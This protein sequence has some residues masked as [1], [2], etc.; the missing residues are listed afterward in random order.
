MLSFIFTLFGIG[1]MVLVH[2]AGHF[3]AARFFK[4]RTDEFSIGFGPV[5]WSR[6][7]AGVQYSIRALPF[8]GFVKIYG[9]RG[10]G[11]GEANSFASRP[12]WQRAVVLVAGVF[13]NVVLAWIFFSSA[14]ILGVPQI[15]EERDTFA[16]VSVLMV[17]PDSPADKAGLKF[18][19]EILQMKS[20]D[21]SLRI[22]SEKDVKD[23][24][25]AY[26]GETITMTVKRGSQI[27]DI[28]LVPRV[29][30]P[31]GEGP[32]G[33]ALGRLV[34]E[35]VSWYQAPVEGART[36]WRVV[37][38]TFQG[39]GT[40]VRDIFVKGARQVPVSGPI[41][42]FFYASDVSV[43]GAVYF[44]H[45]LGIIST[46]LAILNLLPIP[47]LDGGW[48]LFL[49]IEKIKG[50][51]VSERA[52]QIALGTG[53]VLL[54]SLMLFATYQDILRNSGRFRDVWQDVRS[55]F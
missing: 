41:G 1:V 4:I 40:M 47:V 24:A 51:R 44:L 29:N 35:R 50:A 12:V 9:E 16:P 30:I 26:R 55:L 19:D 25:E 2:E 31:D 53:F 15:L 45:F 27:R 36:L 11:A 23:F 49:V 48:V 42:I 34:I 7:R 6:I 37:V 21:I 10:E 3:F 38:A 8:G 54:I 28:A 13:M 5:V 33:I 14:A 18:G 32:L 20:R 17:S 46:S 39:F 52:E 43:L 22:E